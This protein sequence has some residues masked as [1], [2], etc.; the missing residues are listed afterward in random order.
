MVDIEEIRRITD[1]AKIDRWEKELE[2]L[3]ALVEH[4]ILKCASDG[5][6]CFEIYVPNKD[7]QKILLN[8]LQEQGYVVEINRKDKTLGDKERY[9]RI[10]W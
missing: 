4:F 8:E 2:R 7:Y 9:L 3:R 5:E 10:S 1:Q 6:D